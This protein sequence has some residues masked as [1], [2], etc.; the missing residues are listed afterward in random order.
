ML[1]SNLLWNIA[2]VFILGGS[3]VGRRSEVALRHAEAE[4]WTDGGPVGS[5]SSAGVA[6]RSADGAGEPASGYKDEMASVRVVQDEAGQINCGAG[7]IK[8]RDLPL[9]LQRDAEAG[10]RNK[11]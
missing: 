2:L 11:S 5:G 1:R 7:M 8:V 6:A 4:T 3:P 10:R 9:P